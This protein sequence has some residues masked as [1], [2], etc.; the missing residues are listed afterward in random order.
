[1]KKV[2]GELKFV[3]DSEPVDK[4]TAEG[5]VWLQRIELEDRAGKVGQIAMWYQ[6]LEIAG[7][8]IDCVRGQV[9]G[10]G[11]GGAAVELFAEEG[12]KEVLLSVLGALSNLW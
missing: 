9:G 11:R 7:E 3:S 12:K 6:F 1:M 8:L 10:N 5:I 4:P 2:Q